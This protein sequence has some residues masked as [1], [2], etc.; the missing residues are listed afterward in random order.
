V[1]FPAL[2]DLLRA[3]HRVLSDR[4]DALQVEIAGRRTEL[5]K[6][7]VGDAEWVAITA[8]IGA[9]EPAGHSGLGALVRCR[10]GWAL[11][12]TLPVGEVSAAT[13]AATTVRLACEA[14]ALAPAFAP[15]RSGEAFAIWAT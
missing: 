3:R 4:P 12:L 2:L 11:R 6:V 1:T 14:A 10:G 5:F 9:A 15:L 8:W 7:V 13:L